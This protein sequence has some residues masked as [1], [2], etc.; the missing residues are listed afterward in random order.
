[1]QNPFSIGGRASNANITAMSATGDLVGWM[2]TMIGVGIVKPYAI[3]EA[4]WVNSIT[5]TTAADVALQ[6]AAGAG[7]KR[8]LTAMQVQNTSAV[9]TTLIIKDGTTARWT[10]S[11]PASMTLPAEFVFPTPI[12]T[13][14]NAALNAA[15]G[16]TGANVIVNGQGYTAP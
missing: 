5:L 14:A 4:D 2:M 16:T 15:A 7:I 12:P 10:V 3:P 1:M 9:A 6:A 8:Y 11:L 13:S